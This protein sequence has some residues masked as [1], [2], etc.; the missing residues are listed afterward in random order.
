VGIRLLNNR[1]DR[2]DL[3]QRILD[4]RLNMYAG[5]A[6]I[7]GMVTLCLVVVTVVDFVGRTWFYAIVKGG[8][9]LSQQMMALLVAFGLAYTLVKGGHVRVTLAFSRFPP[10]TQLV[11]EVFTDLMGIFLF[12]LLVW[13]GLAHFWQSWIAKEWMPAAIRIPYWPAKLALPL[14]FF[15]MGCEFIVS[16]I[17]HLAE[18]R[19]ILRK[20]RSEV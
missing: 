14:G 2:S 5:F 13:G 1:S 10:K 8:I 17:R 16:L 12:S 7:A 9:E 18:L 3:A 19:R 20:D 15:L 6:F 11:A 4:L